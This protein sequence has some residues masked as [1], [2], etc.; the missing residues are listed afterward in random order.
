MKLDE[1]EKELDELL[2]QCKE[3][4]TL[5]YSESDNKAE[6]TLSKIF[7]RLR[8]LKTLTR[9]SG[10]KDIIHP[11]DRPI[12]PYGSPCMVRVKPCAEEYGG[13]TFLGFLVGHAALSSR[14]S[15]KDNAIICDWGFFNP[16]IYI[17]ENGRVVFGVESWWGEI[18]SVD[19]LKD[20]TDAD[21]NSVWY[22][23]ALKAM[24]ENEKPEEPA[25]EA[26]GE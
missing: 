19:D 6:R 1:V 8:D 22:V 18:K 16:M 26:K 11:E 12:H 20:I 5:G 23:N 25:P 13:K 10:I 21:I 7:G 3:Y 2:A 4:G 9:F 24:T 17:P 14:V 15:I